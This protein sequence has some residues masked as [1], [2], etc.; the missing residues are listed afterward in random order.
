MKVGLENINLIL[1]PNMTLAIETDSK[2][3]RPLFK[4]LNISHLSLLVS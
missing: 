1:P 3:C 4:V 2:S